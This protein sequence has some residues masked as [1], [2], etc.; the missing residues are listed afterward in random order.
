[1]A[2]MNCEIVPGPC[3]SSVLP[4]IL[5]LPRRVVADIGEEDQKE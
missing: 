1:M 2:L 4:D 5:A 3:L